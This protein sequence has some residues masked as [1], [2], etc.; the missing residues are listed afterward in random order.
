ML[1][2][3][4]LILVD[5]VAVSE[6]K[7]VEASGSGGI[8]FISGVLCLTIVIGMVVLDVLSLEAHLSIFKKNVSWMSQ[9][10]KKDPDK[11]KMHVS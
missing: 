5:D 4:I 2:H 10:Q 6:T 8:G 3:W 9:R 11:S 1:Y 7:T